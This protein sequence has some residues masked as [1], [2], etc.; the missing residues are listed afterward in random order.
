MPPPEDAGGKGSFSGSRRGTTV[1]RIHGTRPSDQLSRFEN[2]VWIVFAALSC[3]KNT[4][5]NVQFAQTALTETKDA[6][7][8][9]VEFNRGNLGGTESTTTGREEQ[10]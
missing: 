9:P 8:R 5:T 10:H 6:K 2:C 7:E 3:L 4:V 1:R